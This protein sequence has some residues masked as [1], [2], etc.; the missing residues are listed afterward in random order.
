MT[1]KPQRSE[2]TRSSTSYRVSVDD[3]VC[4]GCGICV[5]FCK[6]AVFEISQELNG[7]G[8]FP[9][10]SLHADQCNNCRLCELACPQLAIVVNPLPDAGGEPGPAGG[11]R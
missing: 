3:S 6:P 9:A 1:G 11:V 2:P 5:F 7:R 4:D 8:V 10:L